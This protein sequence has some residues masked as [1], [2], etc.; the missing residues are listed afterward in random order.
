M[1]GYRSQAVNHKASV[2]K[3]R[4]QMDELDQMLNAMAPPDPYPRWHYEAV[5][6]FKTFEEMRVAVRQLRDEGNTELIE[7][8]YPL[9]RRVLY[10]VFGVE[11]D[12]RDP[13]PQ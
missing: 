1:G 10:A 12:R 4:L 11:E 8:Y 5:E 6:I 13:R 2:N 9:G 7:R 3:V